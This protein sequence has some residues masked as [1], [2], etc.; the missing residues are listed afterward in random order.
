MVRN[1]L[2]LFTWLLSIIILG[3]ACN[4]DPDEIGID[5]QP[6]SDRLNVFATDTFSLRSHSVYVDSVRT[7]E[8]S[9]TMLGSYHDPVFGVT[10]SSWATQ[11]YLS[12]SSVALKDNYQLD[13][14]I[15]TLSY[16][17][18][19]LSGDNEMVAYGDTTTEQTFRMYELDQKLIADT[20]Y[21]SNSEV[22]LKSGEIGN[23]TFQPH[24]TDSVLVDTA[25]LAPQIRI[26][27]NDSFVQKFRDANPDEDFA[28]LSDFLNFLPGI[29]IQPDDVVSGGAIL[30]INATSSGMI[31]YYHTPEEDSL[32]Y[33]FPITSSSARLMNFKHDYSAASPDF[34]NQLN[35]DTALGRNK[36]YV[37]PMA[38]VATII[39]IPHLKDLNKIDDFALNDA[40]LTIPDRFPGSEF[41]PPDELV[42]FALTKDGTKT[43]VEDSFEGSSYYGGTYDADKGTVEFRLTQQLQKVLTKDTIPPRF[44]LGVS[45]ASIL[46]NRMIAN[47]YN[48]LPST[49]SSSPMKLELIFT[50]LNNQ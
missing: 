18:V 41:F 8:T 4:N 27:M 30:F 32:Y 34:I 39:D 38:G 2:R 5:L 22:A 43:I 24:P 7:D 49:G 37:Q 47:G 26:K 46:P 40:R 19:S 42:L 35:G 14:L 12:T 28:S 9:R 25:M 36:F 1:R 31:L 15:L 11:F 29:Y 3:S 33:K 21:Y 17:K 50:R 13:S 6:D 44:Y 16:S 20:S 10:T 48:P 23:I 45:G